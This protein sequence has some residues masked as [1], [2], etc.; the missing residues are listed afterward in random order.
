MEISDVGKIV[1]PGLGETVVVQSEDGSF[2][3][4]TPSGTLITSGITNPDIQNCKVGGTSVNGHSLLYTL[5]VSTTPAQGISPTQ[6]EVQFI[7]LDDHLK[8]KWRF[9]LWSGNESDAPGCD[10]SDT[11]DSRDLRTALT[12]D[13]NWLSVNWGPATGYTNTKEPNF[14]ATDQ[15][16]QAFGA[17]ILVHDESCPN[18]SNSDSYRVLDPSTKKN[19]TYPPVTA[20]GKTHF[21]PS[22]VLSE[23]SIQLW[24]GNGGLGL[25]MADQTHVIARWADLSGTPQVGLI[26]L[27]D[28]KYKNLDVPDASDYT[29]VVSYAVDQSAHILTSGDKALS[30]ISGK[31]VWTLPDNTFSELCVAGDGSVVIS[32]HN[33]LAELDSATGKQKSFSP[34]IAH[35]PT[36]IGSYQ[37]YGQYGWNLGDDGTVTVYRLLP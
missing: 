27:T 7:A 28:L 37:Q 36:A 35:C 20:D 3:T 6:E 29:G 9:K 34:D 1:S 14:I 13:G 18:C 31:T 25:E 16:A 17:K 12:T 4:Y 21:D 30:L 23:I 32:T 22:D 19:K 10:A 33:Q 26:G 2:A 8:E 24:N 11:T 15:D 5:G